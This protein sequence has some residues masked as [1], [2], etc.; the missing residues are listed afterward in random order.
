MRYLAAITAALSVAL[1]PASAYGE[2]GWYAKWQGDAPIVVYVSGPGLDQ[3][4][5]RQRAAFLAAMADWSESPNVEFRL[6]RGKVKVYI[7]NEC[8]GSC[9]I[10]RF[11]NGKLRSVELHFPP[12]RL[13]FTDVQGYF[14]HE[15]GHALGL[16]EGYPVELTGDYGS[17]MASPGEWQSPSQMDFDVLATLYPA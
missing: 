13:E 9:A 5:G 3:M 10:P 8:G 7:D 17:C 2:I 4:D 11:Q 14:C 15:L 16:G 6:G 1:L 12:E